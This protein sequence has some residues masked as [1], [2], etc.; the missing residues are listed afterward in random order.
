MICLGLPW[1]GLE[2]YGD[3]FPGPSSLPGQTF[4]QTVMPFPAV[5]R[6]GTANFCKAQVIKA[7]DHFGLALNAGLSARAQGCS[8]RTSRRP[9]T[10]Y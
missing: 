7:L 5:P 6:G 3:P 1:A 8:R 9:L 4:L 2:A 10:P